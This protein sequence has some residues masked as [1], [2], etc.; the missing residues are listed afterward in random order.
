MFK[1]CAKC[2]KVHAVNVKCQPTTKRIYK[3]EEEDRL[4]HTSRWK[5]KS[6][7][8]REASNYLCAVCLD[9]GEATYKDIEV[10]HITKLRDDPTK[11]LD[12]DNLICLCR[13]HHEMA[14]RG[15][16]DAEYLRKLAN[17]RN[18]A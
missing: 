5:R 3:R 1:A 18:D 6:L 4:R 8:V 15:E 13:Y 12:D 7:E 16:L 14:D 2:G 17:V 11:L 10:H 9:Q